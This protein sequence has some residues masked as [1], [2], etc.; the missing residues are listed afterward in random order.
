VAVAL[1]LAQSGGGLPQAQQRVVRLTG[2]AGAD[3]FRPLRAGFVSDALDAGATREQVQRHGRW[4]NIGS[5][6]AYYG[7][8]QT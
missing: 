4:A 2:A 5:I 1:V 7:K 6:D 3:C 8:T